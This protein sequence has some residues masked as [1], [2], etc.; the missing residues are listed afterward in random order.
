VK[1]NEEI[2][3][4]A[5]QAIMT[6]LAMTVKRMVKWLQTGHQEVKLLETG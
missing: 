1:V 4:V 6:F 3:V 2:A 5:I